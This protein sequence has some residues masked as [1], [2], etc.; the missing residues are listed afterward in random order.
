MSAVTGP[1][2]DSVSIS[3]R[4]VVSAAF[5][6]TGSC[7]SMTSD[8][9]VTSLAAAIKLSATITSMPS[10]SSGSVVSAVGVVSSS[11]TVQFL[12]GTSYKN[13]NKILKTF[14]R[15]NIFL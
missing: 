11:L 7:S 15:R 6:S 13:I 9:R 8:V 4:F 1:E 10:G 2:T 5:G 14:Y 3:A 12:S